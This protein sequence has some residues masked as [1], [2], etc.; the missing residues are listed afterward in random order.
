MLNSPLDY[1]RHILDEAG[2]LA[3]ESADEMGKQDIGRHAFEF[4]PLEHVSHCNT[5]RA[6]REQVRKATGEYQRFFVF[7]VISLAEIYR[8]FFEPVHQ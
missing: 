8:V 3:K 4:L 2:Y 1:I 7:A 5:G 6:V